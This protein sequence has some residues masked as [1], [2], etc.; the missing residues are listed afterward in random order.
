MRVIEYK[1]SD[2]GIELGHLLASFAIIAVLSALGFLYTRICLH[3]ALYPFAVIISSLLYDKL[4]L[5]V[6][7][8]KNV[9]LNNIQVITHNID[10]FL[11][12]SF[13]E[14]FFILFKK[15]YCFI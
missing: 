8:Q 15:F 14:Y 12:E 4:F 6:L 10:F 9:Y 13:F 11:L 3:H 5:L 1:N 2:T 7:R